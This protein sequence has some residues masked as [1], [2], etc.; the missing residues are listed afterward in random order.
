M[1]FTQDDQLN[2]FR[3]IESL[4]HGNNYEVH[5]NLYGPGDTDLSLERS[6]KKL[7]SNNCF[8]SGAAASSPSAA[9]KEILHMVLSRGDSNYGPIDLTTKIDEITGLMNRVFARISLDEAD[10]VSEFGFRKGHPQYPVFWDFAY[11]IHSKKKR[12]LLVGSS[13]D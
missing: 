2:E 3:K 10:S 4:L 13:S 6:M 9:R 12:W 5:F 1:K 7:I 11:D 8:L